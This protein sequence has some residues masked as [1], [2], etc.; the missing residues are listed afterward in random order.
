MADTDFTLDRSNLRAE[1]YL[2]PETIGQIGNFEIR[3]RMIAEGVMSGMHRSPYQGLAVEFAEHRQYVPG[4]DP[5]HIDWKVFGRSDKLYLKQYQQETNLDVVLLVDSSA[6]MRYGTLAVKSGWGGTQATNRMS[7]WTK[8][9]HATATAAAM[10]YLC[11]QQRDRVGVNVF[12]DGV[13]SQLKRSNARDTWRSLVRTLSTETVDQ[14]TDLGK[15]TDQVLANITNR[16]L[17]VLISDLLMPPETVQASLARF[18][19]RR[20]DV[21]L[22]QVLD[23]QE[24]RFE[25]EDP[26]PFDGLEGEARITVDPRSIRDEYLAAMQQHCDSMETTAR[27]LG[28]DYIRMDSHESVGPPLAAL[29][30]RRLALGRG[31]KGMGT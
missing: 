28:F 8:F 27:S 9:D 10:A 15:T 12:A 17:F 25:L 24:L 18:R 19:H 11:L 26:A 20:H 6:S 13:C 4:D 7:S 31:G 2:A 21:I 29:F 16:S 5:K 1:Q 14:P 3:A 22:C 23:R 30:G